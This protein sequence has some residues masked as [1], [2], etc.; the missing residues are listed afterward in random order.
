MKRYIDADKFIEY[1]GFANTKEERNEY[2][3]MQ[4]LHYKTLIIRQQKMYR[5]LNTESGYRLKMLQGRLNIIVQ[6]AT[7]ICSSYC[8]IIVPIAVQRWIRSEQQ[9]LVKNADCN[10]QVI[11]LIAYM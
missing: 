4:L 1:L 10:T 7:I 6:N 5:R 8:M 2:I 9:C 11:A 3:Y